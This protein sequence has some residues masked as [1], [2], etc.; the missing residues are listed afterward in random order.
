MSHSIIFTC[1]N[2]CGSQ[3]LMCM[4]KSRF[5]L[6]WQVI[7]KVIV[8]TFRTYH[9]EDFVTPSQKVHHFDDFGLKHSPKYSIFY[10]LLGK[11]DHR[12]P[13][14]AIFPVG[15]YSF[16]SLFTTWASWRAVAMW[17]ILSLAGPILR[18]IIAWVYILLGLAGNM[19]V[20]HYQP[21]TH[22]SVEI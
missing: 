3:L 1:R 18:M 16:G 14:W 10:V 20:K 4:W 2:N 7:R 11:V 17:R 22:M 15:L 21:K 8:L 5:Y 9:N 6:K 13:G 12:G 19:A